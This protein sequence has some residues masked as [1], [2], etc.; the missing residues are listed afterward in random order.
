MKIK[1]LTNNQSI[2]LVS[3]FAKVELLQMDQTSR[4]PDLSYGLD[5]LKKFNSSL[6]GPFDLNLS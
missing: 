2:S 5:Y 3:H 6:Y 1:W 4:R